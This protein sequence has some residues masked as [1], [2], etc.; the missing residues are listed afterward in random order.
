MARLLF[1]VVRAGTISRFGGSDSLGLCVSFLPH[2]HDFF[3][4]LADSDHSLFDVGYFLNDFL[5]VRE[6]V[7]VSYLA[8]QIGKKRL[9]PRVDKYVL[10]VSIVEHLRV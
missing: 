9:H 3:H 6:K 2:L 1:K 7:R 8:S 5:Q 4:A 10:T